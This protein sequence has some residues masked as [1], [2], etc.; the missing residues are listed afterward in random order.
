GRAIW[1]PDKTQTYLNLHRKLQNL[2]KQ[3]I[4]EPGVEIMCVEERGQAP[5]YVAIR[6]SAAAQGERVTC[7]FPEVLVASNSV[8]PPAPPDN[9][10]LQ[11]ADW[12]TQPS[13]PLTARVLVNRLWH[14]HFGR[15]IVGTPNDFGKL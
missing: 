15:G 13:N 7:G 12:L 8:V 2:R 5:T 4:A 6:G 9:K 14:Y 1:G 3:K 10:R 11:L